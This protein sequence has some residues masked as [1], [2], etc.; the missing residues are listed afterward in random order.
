MSTME[1]S[2]PLLELRD[3][4]RSYSIRGQDTP[5]LAM[6]DISLTLGHG[7]FVSI[8]GPSGCGK[9]TLLTLIS[10]LAKPTTGEVLVEG[11]TVS[12]VRKDV[13]FIFQRDALLP[14][15]TALQNVQLALKFRGVGKKESETAARSWLDR[16]GL[17]G[18]E[19]RYP[20]ELSGGMRKRAAIAA[21]LVY[22]P[23]LLLM[24]EPFSA[25]DVLT[26]DRIETD[27]LSAWQA[28]KTQTAVFVTHDLE[29]A[30]G[31]SDR[32]IVMSRAPGRIIADVAIDLPRPRDL[33]EIRVTPRFR[34]LQKVLWD[35]LREEVIDHGVPSHER[36]F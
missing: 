26:R 28:S 16:F 34:E 5:Y 15:R 30:I 22:E 18:F 3:I 2:S 13:G 10:G 25:L 1:A 8:V 14:W 24:D 33:F 9:S 21:T 4:S 31:M 19:D 29:E 17:A 20:Q 32:V 36:I 27:I 35:H 23:T 7:E 6:T 11:E 12:G